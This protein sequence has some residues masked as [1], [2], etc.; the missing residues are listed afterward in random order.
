MIIV[1]ELFIIRRFF[2][3]I[4]IL[5]TIAQRVITLLQCLVLALAIPALILLILQP[6]LLRHILMKECAAPL[7]YLQ[8]RY[9]SIVMNTCKVWE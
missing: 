9:V 4:R 1:R 7:I 5:L 2:P 8:A 3:F 6:I